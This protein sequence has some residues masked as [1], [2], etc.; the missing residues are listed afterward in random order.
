MSLH[1]GRGGGGSR[2]RGRER[3][4]GE[5]RGVEPALILDRSRT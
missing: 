3:K 1:G 2:H 4:G 5:N